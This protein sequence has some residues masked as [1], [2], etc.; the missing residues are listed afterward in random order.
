VASSR[1]SR[2]L[3]FHIS[4]WE[5][6]SLLVRDSRRSSCLVFFFEVMRVVVRSHVE[7]L[8]CMLIGR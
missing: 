4:R 3:R 5:G 2:I 6:V 7:C 8:E 1:S